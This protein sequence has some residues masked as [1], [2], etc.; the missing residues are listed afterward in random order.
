MELGRIKEVISNNKL[1]KA[2]LSI[3]II[4]ALI[5]YF[6]VFFTSGIYFDD[7]FLKK[8]VISSDN[9]YLGESIYGNI[10]ITVKGLEDKHNSVDVIYRLPNNINMKFTVMYKDK[11]DWDLGIEN[12]KDR[13]GSIVFEGEYT[14]G[15]NFLFNKNGRPILDDIIRVRINNESPY[16]EN[17]KVPLKNVADLASFSN[18]T[19]RGRYDFLVIAMLLFAFTIIDI[20]FPLF[21]F[22]LEHFLHVRD[23]EPSDFYITVQRATRYILPTVGVVLMLAAVY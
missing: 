17:Y 7:V 2:L 14:P 13:D 1:L 16:N 3:L 23:P 20:K 5:F 19:I 21:F 9:H 10:H 8:E 11:N 12:I 4:I 18:D 15:S 6:K 22:N